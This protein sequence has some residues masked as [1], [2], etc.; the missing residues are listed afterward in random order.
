MTSKTVLFIIASSLEDQ[1]YNQNDEYFGE[2]G[3]PELECAKSVYS[4]AKVVHISLITIRS[5]LLFLAF[6]WHWLTKTVLYLE[7]LLQSTEAFLP[8]NVNLPFEKMFQQLVG[9]INFWL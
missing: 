3:P 5:I 9:L 7:Y 4:Y 8:I 1:R 2:G 6:K